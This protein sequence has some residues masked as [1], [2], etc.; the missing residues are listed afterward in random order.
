MLNPSV[1][2]ARFPEA[3]IDQ[4]VLLINRADFLKDFNNERV[5]AYQDF[6]SSLCKLRGSLDAVNLSE[7]SV[8]QP[9]QRC[10]S[11]S[12]FGRSLIQMQDFNR[13][14]AE[15]YK[16]SVQQPVSEIFLVLTLG[17]QSNF[18][19]AQIQ[20]FALSSYRLGN[21]KHPADLFLD[22]SR[23]KIPDTFK[24]DNHE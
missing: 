8:W 14:M 2:F 3:K 18:L 11:Q 10:F 22:R 15:A 5:L 21:L 23:I 20:I 9:S 16:V 1:R 13:G 17:H 24:L 19:Q 6:F 4:V 12:K 7:K